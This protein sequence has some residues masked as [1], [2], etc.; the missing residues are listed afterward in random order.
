MLTCRVIEFSL[1]RPATFCGLSL[2]PSAHADTSQHL[3]A[4]LLFHFSAAARPVSDLSPC[5]AYCSE[6]FG[7]SQK[8]NSCPFKQIHTLAAKYPGWHTL[9]FQ[10]QHPQPTFEKARGGDLSAVFATQLRPQ[11]EYPYTVTHTFRLPRASKGHH[12][13]GAPHSSLATRHFP[14]IMCAPLQEI[15]R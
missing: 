12:G 8:L 13:R 9:V 11:P 2:L 14:R 5:P 1:I 3:P 7:R 10:V 6:L 4:K 15:T